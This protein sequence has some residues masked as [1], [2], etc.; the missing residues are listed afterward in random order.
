[1]DFALSKEEEAFRRE[2]R[3]FFDREVTPDVLEESESGLGWGP[4]TWEFLRKLGSKGWICPSWPQEYGGLGLSPTYRFILH[5]ELDYYR[6]LPEAS[7]V[8]ANMAGPTIILFGSAEQKSEYLPR[9]ARGEIEFALG[10][11]EPEAGSDLAN[12]GLRAEETEDH[13]VLN[14][15]K[16]YSTRCH[17]SHYH[18]LGVRT[19]TQA[20]KHR[21]ISL[22]I[23]DLQSPGIT[24]QPMWTL[25]GSRT[26][27]VF[28]DN[29]LVPKKNLVGEQN[30]GFYYIMTALEFER[31]ITTGRMRRVLEEVIDYVKK[32]PALRRNVLV[33]QRIAQL[34]T[35]IEATRL[36]VFRLA[37]MQSRQI[38]TSYEAAALKV[39][40][41]EVH[42][43]VASTAMDILGLC[44]QLQRDS[45][46]APLQG[47]IASLC[48]KTLLYTFGGGSS[49]IL[50]N[51]IDIRGLG[52]PR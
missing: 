2:V 13:Y 17:F 6:T 22:F 27:E 7:M 42:Q 48:R 8:G 29:V 4:H 25:G 33:R 14:G 47:R 5:D 50:R 15:Q 37:W 20:P 18:W 19:D 35:E 52:L 34:A 46:Y 41:T 26:N 24:I 11:T 32:M 40:G 1:M 3:D 43:R 49:E 28:Y 9:I 44:G 16:V 30:R 45:M 39:L 51:T 31:T 36:L 10:Y 12:L 38:A 21:G 23:V